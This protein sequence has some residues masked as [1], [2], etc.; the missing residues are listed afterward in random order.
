MK[1]V[2]PCREREHCFLNH[3]MNAT[4]IIHARKPVAKRK[5]SSM[6]DEKRTSSLASRVSG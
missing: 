5:E 2:R 6:A 1:D 4:Y 3:D